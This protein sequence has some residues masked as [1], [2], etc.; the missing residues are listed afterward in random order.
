MKR[1]IVFLCVNLGCLGNACAQSAA[2][3]VTVAR[4]PHDRAAAISLT[5]DDAMNTHLNV[6]APILKTHHLAAT[7]FVSTGRN[8]WKTR[9][10]EWQCLAAGGN[11]FGNHTV[12]HP[13][14]LE[15][16]EPHSQNYTPEMM[17]AEIRDA[18]ADIVAT[19]GSRRGLTFAYRCRNM[20]FGQPGDQA[21][22][23]GLYLTY[24]SRY[25]FAGRGY[26]SGD[27]QDPDEMDVLTVTDPGITEAKDFISL[28]A[29]A[30]PAFQKRNWGVYCFYGVGGEWLSITADTL[31]EFAGY[32][33]RHSEIWTAPFGDVV[34]YIQERKASSMQVTT[35]GGGSVD[36][37][38][39]VA[40][41]QDYL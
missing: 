3:K 1:L 24:V 4:W 26:G 27:P 5:F 23:E 35:G 16:I 18:A 29:M 9:K 12:N 25:A 13:C 21:R 41:G 38:P 30:Q 40:V 36:V 33:E 11:E 10:A 34:P 37:G 31:E 8:E 17:E 28:L 7:F 19:T 32:L 14:L 22:N 2:P 20:S 15:V 39:H 6:V